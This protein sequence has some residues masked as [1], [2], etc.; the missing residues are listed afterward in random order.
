[1]EPIIYKKNYFDLIKLKTSDKLILK[2][3][4]DLH[5][6]GYSMFDFPEDNFE[7]IANEI[8]EELTSKFDF[9]QWKKNGWQNNSG[10]R[11]QDEWVL[12]SK[13]RKIASNEKMIEIL[14]I[15]FGKKAFPFQTLNFPVGTQQPKHMD[16]FH[17]SSIPQNFMCG[18]WVA[19]EDINDDSGPLELYESSHKL[20]FSISD[21]IKNKPHL[22]FKEKEDIYQNIWNEQIEKNN[23]KPKKFI[24]R[25]GECVIWLANLLH[26]GSKQNDPN[27]TRWSQVTHYY[28]KDCKYI[29]PAKS[30]NENKIFYKENVHDIS[31]GE[32]MSDGFLSKLKNL[33]N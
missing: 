18:V 8:R 10:L 28:F 23:L 3:A 31:T 6:K 20:D 25:K 27:L 13:I 21:E 33:I 9:D 12:N 2:I 7:N 5:N 30:E 26:G 14:S 32:K 29:V 22:S 17:F 1:M 16:T 15:C 24:A 11:I 4:E 19:L